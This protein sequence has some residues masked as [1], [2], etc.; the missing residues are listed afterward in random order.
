[1][2]IA[3][4]LHLRPADGDEPPRLDRRRRVLIV[5][6]LAVVAVVLVTWLVAFSSVFGVR[7]VEVRGTQVLTAAQVRAA[8]AI[9]GGSPLVRL[10]TGAVARRVDRIAEVSS[11]QVSTSFPSTVVITV[12]ERQPVGYVRRSGRAV[13]VDRTGDQYRTLSSAPAG[14]PHFVVPAGTSARTTG[15]AVATVAAALPAAL[16]KQVRSIEALDA[17]AITLVLTGD[18]VVRWGS[19]A[20]SAD[21]ARVLPVLLRHDVAQVDVSDPDQPFTR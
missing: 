17:K 13:L 6:A 15:G 18:R 2:S 20:R 14:L 5:V 9:D 11:A 12:V 16:R 4:T 8:A 7:T 1:M 3:S 19:A 21:K 10:D